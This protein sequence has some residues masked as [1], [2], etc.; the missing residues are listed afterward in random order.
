MPQRQEVTPQKYERIRAE[1]GADAEMFKRTKLGQ[2][3]MDRCAH[4][5]E[6]FQ[7]ELKV[8]DCDDAKGIRTLQ[9]EIWKHEAFGL[10]LDDAIASGGAAMQNLE[11]MEAYDEDENNYV[12]PEDDGDYVSPP[13]LP[14]E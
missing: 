9:N 4:N 12:P 13:E 1:L 5:V 2:Y 3:I 6:Q 14:G 11:A 7:N 10:W 8:I